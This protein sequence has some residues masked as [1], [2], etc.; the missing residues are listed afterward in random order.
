MQTFESKL[1]AVGQY[2][3]LMADVIRYEGNLL[4]VRVKLDDELTLEILKVHNE[5]TLQFIGSGVFDVLFD[6]REVSLLN[7][8]NKVL[9]YWAEPNEYSQYVGKMAILVKSR[10]HMQLANFYT[11]I[12][13]PVNPSKFFTDETNALNW[14]SGL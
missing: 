5:K 7:V 4:H 8:P 12:F 10:V 13:Q 14:I 3:T 6:V 1:I 11:R 9:R 2:S